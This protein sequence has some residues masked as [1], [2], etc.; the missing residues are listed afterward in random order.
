MLV[1]VYGTLKRG[2]SNHA[3][4][5][6]CKWVSAKAEGIELY[7]GEFFPFAKRG[8]GVAYG[9]LYNVNKEILQRLDRLEGHPH[10]YRRERT[11]VIVEKKSVDAWIYLY[12]RTLEY[13]KIETGV[14]GNNIKKNRKI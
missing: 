4:L 1:F 13:D 2:H 12:P 6:G 5:Q 14:W 10:F 3:L 7:A 11:K 8:K 9:E